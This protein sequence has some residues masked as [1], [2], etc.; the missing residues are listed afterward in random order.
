MEFKNEN[1]LDNI[2][3]LTPDECLAHFQKISDEDCRILGFDP[4]WARPDWMIIKK[5]AVCPPPVRPSV[6][7]DAT[8]RSEDD[9]TYQYIQIL[10]VSQELE[11]NERNG[12]SKHLMEDSHKLLQFFV[13]TLMNNELPAG[14]AQQR[15][16]RPIKAISTRLKGKEGRLRGNL[17][18][19][20]VDFSARSVISP[21]PNLLLDEFDQEQGIYN[22]IKNS[23]NENNDIS[24]SSESNLIIPNDKYIIMNDSTTPPNILNN[25]LNSTKY[26]NKK[27]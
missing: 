14:F 7:V 22:I 21:D 11:K 6:S 27:D 12:A 25:E 13:A 19:K 9:L 24:T 4:K 8:L 23:F 26:K 18:G 3:D 1:G 5:L 20:R 16:G 2:R 15:S 10:K 17:M